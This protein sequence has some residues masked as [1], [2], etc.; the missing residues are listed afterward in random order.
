MINSE[1]AQVNRK[2]SMKLKEKDSRQAG[3]G[4][5][6]RPTMVPGGKGAQALTPR[7]GITL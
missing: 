3:R 1:L 4:R 5:M 2:Q 6:G 7:L